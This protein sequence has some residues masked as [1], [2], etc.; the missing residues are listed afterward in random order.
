MKNNI[1]MLQQIIDANIYLSNRPH[2]IRCE[3]KVLLAENKPYELIITIMSGDVI[4]ISQQ[5]RIKMQETVNMRIIKV[6]KEIQKAEYNI[7]NAEKHSVAF[8]ESMRNINGWRV[9]LQ[10]WQDILIFINDFF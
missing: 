8:N 1:E 2:L 5:E 4:D 9:E 6:S 10:R 3:P 7:K